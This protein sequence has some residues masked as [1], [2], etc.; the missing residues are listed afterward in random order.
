MKRLVFS[1]LSIMV[2][3]G[4]LKKI[5]TPNVPISEVDMNSLNIPQGF[6]F[7]TQKNI[8]VTIVDANPSAIYQ[9]YA[10]YDELERFE[11]VNYIDESGKMVTDTVFKTDVL[12]QLLFSASCYNGKI[13][14]DIIVP[15]YFTH[16]YV[17]RKANG[18]FSSHIAPIVNNEVNYTH[19]S[20]KS[21]T[22]VEDMLYGVNGAGQLFTID[23]RTG[24]L[25]DVSS[26]P[27]GSYT[28]A[29]NNATKELYT[30]Q[31]TKPY[32]LYKYN[33]IDDKWTKIADL[34]FG[35]PRLDYNTKDGFLYFSNND[36]II[37]IDPENGKTISNEKIVG[38]TNLS[39]GDLAFRE[40]GELYLCTFGGLFHLQRSLD[41]WI[42]RRLSSDNLPFSPTSMTFD[43]NNELWLSNNANSSDLI[44][45]DTETGGYEYRF[46]INS[47]EGNRTQI[48]RTI[49]DLTTLYNTIDDPE[50]ADSDNDGIPDS[51]DEYPNDAEKA[52]EQYTPSK[53]GW[54]THAFEDLYPDKGD[55]DFN[56]IALNYKI[57]IIAN[58]KNEIVQI[59]FHLNVK[60]NGAGFING[61]GIEIENIIPSQ[62]EWVHGQL[63]KH[64]Y[65]NLAANGVEA[66]QKN[67]VVIPFDDTENAMGK[68]LLIE[69]KL[70]KPISF[71]A[72]GSQP[73]NPFMIVNK[74]RS[75]E[76]HL[77]Y[78]STTSLGQV[79]NEKFI[80]ENG[81]PWAIDIIHDFKVPLEKVPVNKAYNNFNQW[82]VSG[83]QL[84][85]DWYKDNDGYRNTSY[86]QN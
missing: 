62:V 27:D 36:Y 82:A 53:Y 44:I 39:G 50:P 69:V 71:D 85:P 51:D 83:G 30:I 18:I 26:L 7:S 10:W 21:A 66:N 13:E 5:E 2:I 73:F 45:M 65:I 76:V 3:T 47:I 64:N 16:L 77:P 75:K 29:I 84:Y 9:V 70:N 19:V 37:K 56:D 80:D 38:L 17:R 86:I 22:M 46:G 4:C 59:D 28:C 35:G 57:I 49:N 55:Y 11:L 72:L 20:T 79:E 34:G 78:R 48:K 31:K 68:D 43:K 40:D 1:V 32:P 41:I 8:G 54:G 60:N 15:E 25:T 12:N 33:I 81:L 52:F 42:A 61:Y 58:S 67:V 74:E 14:R 24:N 6:D 23:P 63:H